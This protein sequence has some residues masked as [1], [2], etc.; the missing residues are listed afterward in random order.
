MEETKQ[1]QV[2]D[3]PQL[4]I[5][6]TP[7]CNLQCVY[8]RPG[9]EGYHDNLA[10]RL[11]AQEIITI[12]KLGA[13]VGFTHVKFTG[14][15]PLL[16]PD[17]IMI[18]CDT[19]AISAISEIQIVT[20]GTL[21]SDRAADLKNAGIDW[22]TVSLDAATPDKFRRIRGTDL[23][24]ILQAIRKC[25]SVGLPVRI[26]M[27]VM[28]SNL[29]Q[30]GPMIELATELDCSLKLLDLIWL[31]DAK[32]YEFSKAEFVQ[33][34]VIYKILEELGANRVG[35]EKAPGGVGAPLLEYRVDGLQV[36]VKDS[37]RG[38]YYHS[39]CETCKNY[40]CQDALISVRLTHDGSLKR[41]LIRN[42]NLVP[43]LPLL[44]SGQLEK[45]RE[46]LRDTFLLMT[47]STYHPFAWKPDTLLN[48][49]L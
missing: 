13:S 14:G 46:M 2:S 23:A 38:T 43:L 15:E 29:D 1:V 42:D 20:N 33:F 19:R 8:C 3:S 49:N 17:V 39:T 5:V 36:V 25:R 9:G 45:V 41:C 27:V 48:Q 37:T 12:I 30:I 22:V 34:G 26:N 31:D 40:P 44:R 32:N 11:S 21:L 18:I 24:E 28:K 7:F 16:H 35:I 10:V 47:E 6:L 4:R